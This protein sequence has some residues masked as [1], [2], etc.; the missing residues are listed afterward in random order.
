MVQPVSD[1]EFSTLMAAL[2]PFERNARVAIALSGGPD[3]MALCLLADTWARRQGGRVVALTVDHRLRPD[4]TA[5]AAVVG[6]W[7]GA[8]GIE[9][10]VLAWEGMKP[11]SAVQAKARAARYDLLTGWCR[12]AGILHLA[13]AH[14]MEDQ[15]ETV[16]MRLTRGSG[17]H[18]LAGMSA[19][20]ETAG[21][22][23]L[24]PLLAV[25]R[26]RLTA[27]LRVRRQA[28]VEDPSNLNPAFAR[29]RVRQ[30]LPALAQVGYGAAQL[31]GLAETFAAGRAESEERIAVLLAR[32]CSLLPAGHA[33][34]DRAALAAAPTSTARDALSRV[35]RTVGGGTYPPARDKVEALWSWMAG[36]AGPASMTLARCRCL[37]R[38]ADIIVCREG[39]HLPAPVMTGPG[40]RIFWDERFDIEMGDAAAGVGTAMAGDPILV[41]L[42]REGWAEVLEAAPDRRQSAIPHPARLTL[43]A[44]RDSAGIV[45][46]P[47]LGFRRSREEG[48]PRLF[49]KITFSPRNSLSGVGFCLAPPV[50]H[51]I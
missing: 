5:E 37:R 2:G 18:G 35:L 23:I 46:V 22:R 36:G 20:S 45:E 7:M 47:Y 25:E 40:E 27:T 34:L 30:W 15:A 48:A 1:P 29:V 14:E 42:G 31:Q 10:R 11:R 6:G 8:L 33:T 41:P 16:L 9:H 4:S 26:A 13:L 39:R 49:K 19:V 21:V 3:S 51:T 44:V 43:P 38:A 17:P 50:S 24:R 32:A 12:R 28:W